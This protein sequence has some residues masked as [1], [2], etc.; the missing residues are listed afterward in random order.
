MNPPPPPPVANAVANQLLDDAYAH[1]GP[2]PDN[3]EAR[4][5]R[6]NKRAKLALTLHH[7]TNGYVTTAEVGQ[8]VI[9]ATSEAV[10]ASMNVPGPPVVLAAIQA[11]TNTVN[12]NHANLTNSVNN[13]NN[14]VNNL[15]NTVNNIAARQA[16]S[17]ATEAFDHLLPLTNA[18]GVLPPPNFPTTYQDL[19]NLT[20]LNIRALLDFYGLPRQP[21]ANRTQRLRKHLGLPR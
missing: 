17:V 9:H 20:A 18:A 19:V 16:N 6:S 11:L 1:T 5:G 7:N 4:V 14:T 12:N 8:Q 21:N 3:A 13:L 10:A 2:M 15:T